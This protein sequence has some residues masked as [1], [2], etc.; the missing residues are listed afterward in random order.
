MAKYDFFIAGKWRNKDNIKPVLDLVRANGKTAY[1]FIENSFSADG[2]DIG[3]DADP[4]KFMAQVESLPLDN[5]IV[6]R[7][8]EIDM[9]AQREAENYLVVFPAG[10]AAHIEAGAAYG[11]GKKCYAIGIPEKTETLYCIFDKIFQDTKAFSEW[12]VDN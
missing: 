3:M 1:C 12:L 2:V 9:T 11:M 4:N 5:H 8:F 7:F 10:N 6:R